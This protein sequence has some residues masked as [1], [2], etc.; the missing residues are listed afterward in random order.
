MAYIALFRVYVTLAVKA[1]H[2]VVAVAQNFHNFLAYAR[3]YEHIKDNIERIGKLYAYFGKR[4]AYGTHGVRYN[5][6]GTPLV[7]AARYIIKHFIAFRWLHPMVCRAGILFFAGA[8]ESPALNARHI[9]NR[10]AVQVAVGE[11]ILVKAYHFAGFA[12]C[13]PQ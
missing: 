3:H 5:V 2:P 7:A 12:G 11:F 6:H 10:G 4:R 13:F 9:V 8:Y 1:A